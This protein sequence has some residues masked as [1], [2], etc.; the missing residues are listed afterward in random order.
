MVEPAFSFRRVACRANYEPTEHDARRR[1]AAR[2][3]RPRSQPLRGGAPGGGARC[4]PT[5][6]PVRRRIA[7]HI[8]SVAQGA[9]E[10]LIGAAR[11]SGVGRDCRVDQRAGRPRARPLAPAAA[12][13]PAIAKPLVP[14]RGTVIGVGAAVF[15]EGTGD[16]EPGSF[17]LSAELQVA[18]R[19]AE[20]VRRRSTAYRE[21]VHRHCNSASR[22][23]STSLRGID[24]AIAHTPTAG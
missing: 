2:R 14:M 18:T 22:M 12:S 24:T 5:S 21:Q 23:C 17:R 4:L 10:A 9:I 20:A 7:G 6:A 13:R 15:A 16:K 1:V 19:F 3:G 8:M 11:R